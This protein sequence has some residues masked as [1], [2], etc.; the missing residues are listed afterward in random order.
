M[1]LFRVLTTAGS[2]IAIAANLIFV[3]PAS[4]DGFPD[5]PNPIPHKRVPHKRTP[6]TD[7]CRQYPV[8]PR[9][10]TRY[11]PE[12][13]FH[14]PHPVRDDHRPI[15]RDYTLRPVITYR[16]YYRNPDL[17]PPIIEPPATL[18]DRQAMNMDSERVF[19]VLIV[20]ILWFIWGPGFRT[21][22][23]SK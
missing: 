10:Q 17:K 15:E 20:L 8:H 4:A 9:P 18:M 12:P 22:K 13:D 1:K 14:E 6:P 19:V 21:K 2:A 11:H 23:D 5:N 3:G 16:D 7:E